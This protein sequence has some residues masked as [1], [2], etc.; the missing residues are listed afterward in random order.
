MV[1]D[2]LRLQYKTL[3]ALDHYV[4]NTVYFEMWRRN[5]QSRISAV[6]VVAGCKIKLKV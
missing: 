4:A 6:V 2:Y 1:M 3:W 5:R